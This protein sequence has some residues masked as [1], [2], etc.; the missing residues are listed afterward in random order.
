[1]PSLTRRRHC[2]IMR[3]SRK[4]SD[5]APGTHVNKRQDSEQA[6]YCSRHG[7]DPTAI[8]LSDKIINECQICPDRSSL[9]QIFKIA[10]PFKK[11]AQ[12]RCDI[13][14]VPADGSFLDENFTK[15]SGLHIG[16]CDNAGRVLEFDRTGL[17]YNEAERSQAWQ[18]CVALDFLGRLSTSERV[19][20]RLR[21]IWSQAVDTSKSCQA[22]YHQESY[23]CLDFVVEFLDGFLAIVSAD[24]EVSQQVICD[25]K[26]RILDKVEFCRNFVVR[27]TSEV[28][29]YLVLDKKLRSGDYCIRDDSFTR[30]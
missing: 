29:R 4:G 14:L 12:V 19:L 15:K 22:T 3:G 2:A 23:N 21:A 17:R 24:D 30:G 27:Q 7:C 13:V 10:Y 5:S 9:E 28:A 25:I 16:I 1:M 26:S 8:Q 20:D 11:A 18:Q 6:I